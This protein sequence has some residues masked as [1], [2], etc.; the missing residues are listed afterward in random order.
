MDG[1]MELGAP[2]SLSWALPSACL[3]DPQWAQERP[4]KARE[5]PG[6]DQEALPE[7]QLQGYLVGNQGC[8][9]GKQ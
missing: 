7:A 4:G 6:F 3:Q 1:Q 8:L 5:H 2:A 9:V